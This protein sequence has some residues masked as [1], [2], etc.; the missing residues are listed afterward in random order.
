MKTKLLCQNWSLLFCKVLLYTG[1]GHDFLSSLLCTAVGTTCSTLDTRF[2]AIPLAG[3]DS[4][5][6]FFEN[7]SIWLTSA[8]P[9]SFLIWSFFCF[10]RLPARIHRCAT[11]ASL[12]TPLLPFAQQCKSNLYS[13]QFPFPSNAQC[14]SFLYSLHSLIPFL[15]SDAVHHLF[16]ILYLSILAL[17]IQLGH[18]EQQLLQQRVS[19]ELR[20]NPSSAWPLPSRCRQPF[21]PGQRET[22]HY[23][24]RHCLQCWW[25]RQKRPAL[26]L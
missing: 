16:Y 18:N 17:F 19:L 15:A 3:P 20:Q 25:W 2:H 23:W 11:T 9:H 24:D 6:L 4:L 12:A 10:R 21:C 26:Q 7:S 13:Q 22:S 5:R 14:L 8:F 1:K